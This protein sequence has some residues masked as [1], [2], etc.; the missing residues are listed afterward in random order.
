MDSLRVHLYHNYTYFSVIYEL[1][2]H[3]QS[4]LRNS[5]AEGGTEASEDSPPNAL[6]FERFRI[7]PVGSGL[8]R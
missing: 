3:P 7:V 4:H 5:S 8:G 2:L 6:R 1:K